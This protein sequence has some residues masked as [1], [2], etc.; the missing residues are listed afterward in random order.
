M[1]SVGKK[2]QWLSN[3]SDIVTRVCDSINKTINATN[4]TINATNKTINGCNICKVHVM[5]SLKLSS[6]GQNSAGACSFGVSCS[7]RLLSDRMLA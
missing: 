1:P 2:V 3:K 5:Y 4:N 7:S 6:L